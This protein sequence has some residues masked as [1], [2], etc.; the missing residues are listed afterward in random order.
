[1]LQK[2]EPHRKQVS[3]SPIVVFQR[4]DESSTSALISPW[5]EE[6]EGYLKN[7][8]FLILFAGI[9]GYIK[10]DIRDSHCQRWFTFIYL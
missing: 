6:T 4:I 5:V 3:N 1:M 7:K 8:A 10:I 2:L 9:H